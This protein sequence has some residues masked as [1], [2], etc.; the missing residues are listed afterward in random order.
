MKRIFFGLVCTFGIFACGTPDGSGTGG[1]NGSQ[2]CSQQHSCTNGSC[3][4]SEGPNM[5]NSC[6]SP[7]DTSCTT[8][9]CDT[10]CRY[11]R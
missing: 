9:K 10:Y 6:C 5:G 7:S 11:C 8:N 3:T 2:T 4:C 1:G